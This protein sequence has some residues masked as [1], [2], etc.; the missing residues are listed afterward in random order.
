M[1]FITS[2]NTLV[3]TASLTQRG[4]ELL[5]Q[6]KADFKVTYFAVG[7][8]DANYNVINKLTAGFVPDLTG[9]NADCLRSLAVNI[10]IKNKIN[11]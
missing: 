6:N 4:R 8:S 3:I 7:D 10:D 5:L 2:G 9:D 11:K 1:G